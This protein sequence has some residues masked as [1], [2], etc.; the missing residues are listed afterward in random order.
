MSEEARRAPLDEIIR[1]DVLNAL[2]W[3]TAVPRNSVNVDVCDGR[4]TLTG[5]VVRAFASACAERDAE[6]TTGVIGVTNAI[7]IV[8]S[9]RPGSSLLTPSRSPAWPRA[10]P[11]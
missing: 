8:G 9:E 5:K 4:V 11:R 2:Y 7:V 3:D 6:A 1:L 10:A